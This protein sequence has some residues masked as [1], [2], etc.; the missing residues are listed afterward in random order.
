MYNKQVRFQ[1]C[2]RRAVGFEVEYPIAER[3]L[4][5]NSDGFH[6]AQNLAWSF[7]KCEIETSF[8]AL[9]RGTYK[10]SREG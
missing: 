2:S 1:S 3:G 4:K 10:M 9:T 8:I 5:I 7:F 6:I